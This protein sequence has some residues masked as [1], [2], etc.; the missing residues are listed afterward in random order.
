MLT[1]K[2]RRDN[3]CDKFLANN[4]AN[5]KM[6]ELLPN[7]TLPNYELRSG[8]S[9]EHY[10]CKTDRFQNS[11]LPQ[12]VIRNNRIKEDSIKVEEAKKLNI[13]LAQ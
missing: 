8:G 2:E 4:Q 12:C 11:F 10:Q 9:Y 3:L 1:L 7:R 13:I 5:L 6:N